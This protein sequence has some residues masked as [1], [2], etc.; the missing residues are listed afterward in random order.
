[1]TPIGKLLSGG[2]AKAFVQTVKRN[3]IRVSSCPTAASV[4]VHRPSYFSSTILFIRIVRWDIVYYT[5][6][7]TRVQTCRMCPALEWLHHLRPPTRKM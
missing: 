7:S 6:S 4:I 1:M 3:Y 5:N 2:M